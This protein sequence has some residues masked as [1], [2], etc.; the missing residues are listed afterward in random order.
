MRKFLSIHP[1]I[2]PLAAMLCFVA[3]VGRVIV[4]A[5]PSLAVQDVRTA[6]PASV[7]DDSG[8]VSFKLPR[9]AKVAVGNRTTGRITVIGWD[10]DTVEARAVSESGI[11]YVRTRVNTDSSGTSFS[12]KADYAAEG[13]LTERL[14]EMKALILNSHKRGTERLERRL[15][16]SEAKREEREARSAAAPNNSPASVVAPGSPAPSAPPASPAQ[17]QIPSITPPDRSD[18]LRSPSFVMH[19]QEIHLEVKV[20]RYAEI[21]VIEVYRSDVE[22]SGVETHVAVNGG[23][24]TIK[25]NNVGSAEVRTKSGAVEVG[26]VRGLVDVITTSGSI[27]VRKA[28]SDVRVISISGN[29]E[30]RCVRGRVNVGNTDGSIRL[31]GIGGDIDATTTGSDIRFTGDIRKDGRYHLKSMSG[32]V[33]MFLSSTP[34]GFTAVLSSYRGTVEA[35]LPLRIAQNT[36]NDPIN[37]RL[38]GRYGNGQAHLT[39]D[40]FDGNVKLNKAAPA[41]T[42]DCR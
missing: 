10:R 39:L 28:G 24:S 27:A 11:E 31:V 3:A 7:Q 41:A 37:R 17:Q 33:E 16:E 4:T 40:S 9:G 23:K 14:D 13:F 5:R 20:P 29:V 22:V 15:K 38:V 34:A 18:G 25:L 6:E 19:R 36:I 12:L 1:L 35:T 21:E 26:E 2:L 32:L 42:E 30:I 8:L